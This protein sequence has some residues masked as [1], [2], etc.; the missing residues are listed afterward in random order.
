MERATAI[1]DWYRA[2]AWPRMRRVLVV[3]PALLSLGGLVVGVSFTDA[4]TGAR[5]FGGR[6]G[7]NGAGRWPGQ[8]SR[9]RP[10]TASC[11]TT[12][13]SA[14]R[15]DGVVFRLASLEMALVAWEDLARARW[16]DARGELTLERTPGDGGV[17]RTPLVVPHRFA[18]IAGAVLVQKIEQARRRASMGFLA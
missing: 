17:E 4:R 5:A 7:R 6:D 18:G 14:I 3:G 1:L 12:R 2:D 13:T 15:T 16:D 10:C 8:A 9:W 11:A